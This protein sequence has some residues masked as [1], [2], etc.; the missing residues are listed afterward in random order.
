MFYIKYLFLKIVLLQDNCE[1]YG[2]NFFGLCLTDKF[3][4]TKSLVDTHYIV[5]RS[6]TTFH[7]NSNN[8]L[9]YVYKLNNIRICDPSGMNVMTIWKESRMQRSRYVSVLHYV[10]ICCLL[11]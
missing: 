11:L 6:I 2:L 7:N 5:K 8:I 3:N 1:R 4:E 10:Y 9:K